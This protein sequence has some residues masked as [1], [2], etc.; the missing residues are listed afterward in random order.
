MPAV[1]CCQLPP[2]VERSAS[3]C[4]YPSQN[5]HA[6]SMKMCGKPYGLANRSAEK[7]RLGMGNKASGAAEYLE[8][9]AA[10][11]LQLVDDPGGGVARGVLFFPSETA[12]RAGI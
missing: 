12:P 9:S 10:G 6:P 11:L 2:I 3:P 4:Y 1:F 7:P 8:D 5:L